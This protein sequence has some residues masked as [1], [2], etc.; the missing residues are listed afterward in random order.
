MLKNLRLPT[1]SLLALAVALSGCSTISYYTHLAKGQYELLSHRKKITEILADPKRDTTLRQRLEHLQTARRYASDT[2]HLPD[3]ASYTQYADL[4]R[5][6]VVW[7]VLAAPEFSVEPMQHCFW[8]VGCLAYRGYFDEAL[9]RAEAQRLAAEHY[10]VYVVGVPAYSTLGWF[11]DPVLNTM[12]AW[13]DD[14]LTGTL[15]HELAH[16][17]L[18]IRD[19]TAFNESFASFVEDE[20]LR[21]Y[22]AQR[23][24]SSAAHRQLKQRQQQFTQMMLTARERLAALYTAGGSDATQRAGKQALFAQ[25]RQDYTLLR[26]QQWNGWRGYDRWFEGDL[27]NARLLPFALYDSWVPAFEVL[28]Q[29]S[30]RQW[31]AFY[32]AAR[33]LGQLE[34][35]EREQR[36]QALLGRAAT[37]TATPA[38]PRAPAP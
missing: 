31:P 33:G 14:W 22:Q 15:F 21:Q 24:G 38:A 30:G 5:S 17:Q 20:G 23:G 8:I 3:N 32:A 28:F 27:N 13:D 37:T 12:M 2:L 10:D 18:Y 35:P 6:Y 1:L 11:D 4:G 36:L 26:D 19:D 7:N 29:D 25:L 9:A 16:Q 34:A